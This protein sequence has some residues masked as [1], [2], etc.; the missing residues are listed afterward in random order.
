MRKPWPE[1]ARRFA[2]EVVIPLRLACVA[3]TGW[4]LVLSLWYIF[5]ED[6]LWCATRQ[7]ARLVSD[8]RRNQRC[9]WE[10]A[11]DSMPYCGLR[12][13]AEAFIVT[14]RGPE[15]LERLLLRYLGTLEA[16]L[17]HRLRGRAEPEV[18]IH[19]QP[20]TLAAWN[21]ARRMP[22][23]SGPQTAARPCPDGPLRLGRT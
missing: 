11:S 2:T 7:G 9:G 20:V 14:E 13:Q 10:I 8:L 23:T 5:E 3:E 17:A 22:G 21:Y 12:G 1:D 16:P 18:A 19:L 6:S 15:I 4:P